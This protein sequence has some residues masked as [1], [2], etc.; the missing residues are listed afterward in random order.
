MKYKRGDFVGDIVKIII[1]IGIVAAFG[2]ALYK[3]VL[4]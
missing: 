2:F 1:L 3:G 4:K